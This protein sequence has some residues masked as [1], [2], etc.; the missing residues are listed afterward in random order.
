MDIPA[1]TIADDDLTAGDV[2]LLEQAPQKLMKNTWKFTQDTLTAD[3][4]SSRLVS[5]CEPVSIAKWDTGFGILDLD[6][7]FDP[8]HPHSLHAP[9]DCAVAGTGICL[10]GLQCIIQRHSGCARR[11]NLGG[12]GPAFKLLPPS[13]K[14]ESVPMQ[15]CPGWEDVC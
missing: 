11:D 12:G 10:T 1:F 14:H 15:T 7:P 2:C 5:G 9:A 13:R 4:E 6:K 8:T 3:L